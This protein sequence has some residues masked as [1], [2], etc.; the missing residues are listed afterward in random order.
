MA[1]QD[2]QCEVVGFRE[3]TPTVFEVTFN[4]TPGITFESGQFISIIVAG[5]GPH[6]RDLRR[7]Y[8]IASAP[9][10][11]PIELCVKLVDGGPGTNFLYQLRPGDRFRGMAPYGDFTYEPKQGRHV[12][13]IAT[14]T[15]IAPFRSMILSETFRK[16]PPVSSTCLLGVSEE[17]EVL[18]DSE[19]STIPGLRW[20]PAVSRPK[21]DWKGFRGRVTDYL[22]S[23][24]S[25]FPWL[26]TDYYL[27]GSGAMIDEV[28]QILSER[29]VMKD[30]IHQEVYFKSPKEKQS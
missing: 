17:S 23:M 12:C 13:F 27:C 16:S 28:K 29:G 11:R 3:L 1:A 5:A 26:E 6:G 4:T 24:G 22:R 8:S 30:A 10:I 19:M 9:H 2:L 15:G 25:D 18:Y 14:G 7:A 20:V 21:G